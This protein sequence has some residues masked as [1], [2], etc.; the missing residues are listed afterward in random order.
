MVK[1]VAIKITVGGK[2]GIIQVFDMLAPDAVKAG[3]SHFP[4]TTPFNITAVW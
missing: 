1:Y 2:A 4:V 3:I